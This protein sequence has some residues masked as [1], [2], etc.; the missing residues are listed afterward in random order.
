MI[1]DKIPLIFLLFE[2]IYCY[3]YLTVRV[4]SLTITNMAAFIPLTTC[5]KNELY[6]E[7]VQFFMII[8]TSGSY[9]L[10][11]SIKYESNLCSLNEKVYVISDFVNSFTCILSVI[12]FCL[13]KNDNNT[14]KII[15][16]F[17]LSLI[18]CILLVYEFDSNYPISYC[19]MIIIT[20]CLYVISNSSKFIF[21]LSEIKFRKLTLGLILCCFSFLIYLFTIILKM[22][23]GRDYWILHSYCWH[24]PIFVSSSLTIESFVPEFNRYNSI[25]NFGI[26]LIEI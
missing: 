25:N 16:L 13:L 1:V 2:I 22:S 20:S 5:I 12:L 24:I 26:E 19:L 4:L 3:K 23:T 17:I 7:A 18:Y 8:L 15:L 9:H 21:P 14:L 11:N 6:I 10:C